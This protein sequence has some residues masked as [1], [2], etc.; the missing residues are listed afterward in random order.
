MSPKWSWLGVPFTKGRKRCKRESFF[1]PEQID[2]HF[3][4]LPFWCSTRADSRE[5]KLSAST[6]TP[7]DFASSEA[8]NFM[9]LTHS[10]W[11][12]FTSRPIPPMTS[13]EVMLAVSC[14]SRQA[15]D[16]MNS[17]AAAN[18]GAADIHPLEDHVR[19]RPRRSRRPS[20]GRDVDGHV[21]DTFGRQG[22]VTELTR[23]GRQSNDLN[24]V[25]HYSRTIMDPLRI[26]VLHGRCGC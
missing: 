23:S 4:P 19:P 14:D 16:A 6:I 20:F 22:G 15:V 3:A 1:C 5:R 25:E 24:K 7:T 21:R 9:L 12:I 18:G 13:S 17:A 10:K 2:F 11:R 8:I 26:D